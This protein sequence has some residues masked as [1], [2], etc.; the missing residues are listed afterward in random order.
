[1]KKKTCYFLPRVGPMALSAVLL[2]AASAVLRIVWSCGEAALPDGFF[3][4]Q[5]VLP[6]LANLTFVIIVFRDGRDRLYRTA[7]PV[8]LGCVFFAAKALTFPSLLHTVLCLGLYALVAALYTATVTVFVP[9]E[10]PL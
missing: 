10:K 5:I 3:W 4:I 6:L 7:I 1:M 8:W 9:T 2:M